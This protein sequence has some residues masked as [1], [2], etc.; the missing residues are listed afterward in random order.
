MENNVVVTGIGMVTPLGLDTESTWEALIAGRSGIGP[1]TL[2]DPAEF[3]TKIAAEVKGFD[4][5]NWMDRKEA[6]RSDRFV[7]FSVAASKEAVARAG[8]DPATWPAEETGVIIGSGIGG[9]TT[10]SEQFRVLHDKGPDRVSP[11]LIPMMITDMA[12]GQVSISLGAKGPNY[13]VTSACSTGA[14]SIGAAYEHI[15]R[16]DATIMLAGGSEA[17]ITPIGIAAFNAARALSTNNAACERASCPF[18]AGRDGF[19][20]GEGATVLVLE[21]EGHARARGAPILAELRGYGATSDA[22]HIT[23]PSEGGEGAARAMEKALRYSRL[24]PGEVAYINAHGTSTPLNDK[25]ETQA[26]KTVFG[27]EAYR[28]P[29]SSTKSM[30]GHLLGGAGALEAAICVL[31]IE[32]GQ[33]PPTINYSTPDP[34]C[35]LDYVP[36][37]M[38]TKRVDVALTNS[39]GFGGHNS[40]LVFARPR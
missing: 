29:I 15:R 16:G 18:D 5:T 24:A 4:P 17:S 32:R 6:R 31:A 9:L 23:Q 39:Q 1:I 3:E 34:E 36:N 28:V 14:D 13:C 33:I 12:S 35:D 20:M 8:L 26:I 21:A 22:F 27:A 38:R 37:A 2:F 10:L 7:Q 40:C 11:F 30:V 25:T 19:V